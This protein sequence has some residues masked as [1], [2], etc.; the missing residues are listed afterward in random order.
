M[1]IGV[2][3]G[4]GSGKTYICNLLEIANI[5]VFN[6]DN[7]ASDIIN[8]NEDVKSAIIELF[9]KSSYI[10]VQFIDDKGKVKQGEERLDRTFIASKIF[11]DPSLREKM[12]AIVHPVV[13]QAFLE[14]K[15]SQE[16]KV[17]AIESAILFESGFNNFVDKVV[18]VSAPKEVRI[19]RLKQRSGLTDIE[20]KRRMDSQLSDGEKLRNADFIITNDL[21]DDVNR[22][23]FSLLES[24]KEEMY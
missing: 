16:S 7:I 20:I 3:G 9:G 1:I 19:Q 2:T 10:E 15:E 18:V 13:K 8:N 6:C 5:P 17:V 12:N 24:I 23:I 21:H 4:I 11:S 22:Q 14:W